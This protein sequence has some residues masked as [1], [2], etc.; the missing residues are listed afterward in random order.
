M[1]PWAGLGWFGLLLGPTTVGRL[2][3]PGSS[4]HQLRW[5][6]RQVCSVVLGGVR[7]TCALSHVWHPG[8]LLRHSGLLCCGVH[9]PE[10]KVT[11]K[12][13]QWRVGRLG[14]V[15]AKDSLMTFSCLPHPP[16][17]Q[18][19]WWF[20]IGS[21]LERVDL[22]LNVS[23]KKTQTQPRKTVT[24]QDGPEMEILDATQAHVLN[25]KM[26]RWQ[27]RNR[28][29]PPIASCLKGLLC[30]QVGALQETFASIREATRIHWLDPTV[31][32][33]C[34]GTNASERFQT[35][36]KEVQI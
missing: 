11:P 21:L 16:M 25:I 19:G 10:L 17:K 24:T 29:G 9:W 6:A 31:E 15:W 3:L 8:L 28:L 14:I 34:P 27:R 5:L 7:G 30:E 23:K 1:R 18:L 12:W 26:E 22:V 35:L 32:P 2:W 20:C 4:G 36:V 33:T 13:C